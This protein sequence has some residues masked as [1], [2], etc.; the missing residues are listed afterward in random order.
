MDPLLL[1]LSLDKFEKK[2]MC[3]YAYTCLNTTFE[4]EHMH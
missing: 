3:A 1:V 2:K 4:L